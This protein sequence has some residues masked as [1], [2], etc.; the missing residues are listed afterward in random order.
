MDKY[1]FLRA[2]EKYTDGEP[3]ISDEN[4]AVVEYVY[5]WHPSISVLRGNDQIAMLYC[6]FG[7]NVINDMYSRAEEMQ[8]LDCD[9]Q[10]AKAKVEEIENKIK[11]E[12]NA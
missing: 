10:E 1:E 3:Y 4:F 2:C 6:T 11:D 9:L 12:I 8:L 5:N 7:M